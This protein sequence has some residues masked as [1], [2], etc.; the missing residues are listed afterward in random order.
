M[1]YIARTLKNVKSG[2]RKWLEDLPQRAHYRTF[3]VLTYLADYVL[4]KSVNAPSTIRNRH[5]SSK[6]RRRYQMS[7][8]MRGRLQNDPLPFRI[9]DVV[10]CSSQTDL[11]DLRQ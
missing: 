8:K 6:I 5:Q 3:S 9:D 11:T 4:P 1:Y 2:F 10:L 7:K